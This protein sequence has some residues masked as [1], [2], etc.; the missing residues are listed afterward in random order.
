MNI[1]PGTGRGTGEAGGGG[2]PQAHRLPH[3]PSINPLPAAETIR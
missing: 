3:A 2:A 1:L